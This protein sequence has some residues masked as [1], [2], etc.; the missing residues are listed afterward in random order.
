[1][2]HSAL[3]ALRGLLEKSEQTFSRANAFIDLFVLESAEHL[4][5]KMRE[6]KEAEECITL[7]TEY[8]LEADPRILDKD[9]LAVEIALKI[10]NLAVERGINLPVFQIE[11]LPFPKDLCYVKSHLAEAVL[12]LIEEGTAV[13][14]A[15]DFEDA[16]AQAAEGKRQG[17]LL[18][19]M[20]ED[21]L[22]LQGISRLIDEYDL[23][24]C[25]L[26]LV[27]DG[28]QN[29]VYLLLSCALRPSSEANFLEIMT[30]GSRRRIEKTLE[31]A[32]RCR[33]LSALPAPLRGLSEPTDGEQTVFCRFT[34]QGNGEDLRLFCGILRLCLPES[35]IC[36]FYDKAELIE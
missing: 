27:D 13:Y 4:L 16:C 18:P 12:P 36:G 11:T 28:T 30:A 14:Y 2:D 31:R 8:L 33:L 19:Y 3:L 24:K 21:R 15:D 29:T 35:S 7:F 5:A 26:F 22:P 20:G 10:C 6:K 25:R 1:M 32:D 34:L 23:K 17:C 9:G